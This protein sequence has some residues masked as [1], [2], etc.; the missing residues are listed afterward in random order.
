MLHRV[1]PLAVMAE[2]GVYPHA[3]ISHS[4]FSPAGFMHG[5]FGHRF[6]PSEVF[7]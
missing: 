7:E 2:A 5:T 3:L 4:P 6:A 1:P